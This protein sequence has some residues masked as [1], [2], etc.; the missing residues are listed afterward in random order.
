MGESVSLLINN[1]GSAVSPL[2]NTDDLPLSISVS[3]IDSLKIRGFERTLSKCSFDFTN[4][5]SN[6]GE[7]LLSLGSRYEPDWEPDLYR[8]K[9]PSLRNNGC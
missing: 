9:R 4:D 7:L 8:R 1:D 6:D 3:G 2:P 5:L